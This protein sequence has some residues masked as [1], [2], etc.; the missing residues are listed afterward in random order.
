MTRADALIDLYI[1]LQ[2]ML[3][4]AV[5]MAALLA[6]LAKRALPAPTEALRLTLWRSALAAG[7]L[8]PL[9]LAGLAA[10]RGGPALDSLAPLN[11]T[12]I[13]LAQ[14]LQ[15]NI[16]VSAF[17]V[18]SL[19]GW[20]ETTVRDLAA[21]TSVW[22]GT[23]LGLFA[24]GMAWH[25]GRLT[26]ALWRLRQVVGAS[27]PWR[28]FAGVDLRLSDTAAI[29]FAARGLRRR[30]VVMPMSLLA[31]DTDL[32]IAVGHELQHL[33]QADVEWELLVTLLRP[34]FFWN[35][36]F[37][38]AARRIEALRELS[39][40]RSL[41]ARRRWSLRAYADCLLAVSADSLSRGRRTPRQ[42]PVVGLISP[43]GPRGA[44]LRHRLLTLVEAAPR[45]EPRRSPL[46]TA[47][48]L[49]AA[50]LLAALSMQSSADWSQDRLMLSTIVNLERLETLN[51][52]AARN[53]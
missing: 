19:L 6:G 33:R 1:D 52:L 30:I 4:V 35:P 11:V 23:V 27:Y 10:W 18:E 43:F 49:A 7:L 15:G 34:L 53:W 25:L 47:L 3:A 48:P 37:I 32:R 38:L 44:R 28:R 14:F 12:D 51:A 40:D 41:M 36:A 20:R 16:Q 46:V 9:V 2:L 26:L 17:S 22:A 8:S 13:F 21:G 31:R 24:A 45:A 5:L 29:P 39:C 42:L 50:V